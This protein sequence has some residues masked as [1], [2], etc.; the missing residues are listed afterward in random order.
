MAPVSH[1]SLWADPEK[2]SLS[3]DW[4]QKNSE[5]GCLI[6]IPEIT[7]LEVKYNLLVTCFSW[8]L[9]LSIHCVFTVLC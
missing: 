8:S 1:V 5:N 6:F 7:N 9:T 4:L 2:G 3:L